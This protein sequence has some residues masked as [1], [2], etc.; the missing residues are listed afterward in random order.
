M[1]KKNQRGAIENRDS[2]EKLNPGWDWALPSEFPHGDDGGCC[3][4]QGQADGHLG[5]R[6][7]AEGGYAES[8]AVGM[9]FK[10]MLP[11]LS[12]SPRLHG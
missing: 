6:L 1:R 10:V 12:G 7:G 8:E 9:L 5:A 11:M 3:S 2:A 4:E